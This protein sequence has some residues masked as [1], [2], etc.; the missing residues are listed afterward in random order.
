MNSL[1]LFRKLNDLFKKYVKLNNNL[2]CNYLSYLT[3]H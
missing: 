3:Y 1:D 2:N